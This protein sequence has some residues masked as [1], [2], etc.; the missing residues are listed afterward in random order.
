MNDS[1][2]NIMSQHVRLEAHD[3]T[4]N[5]TIAGQGIMPEQVQRTKLDNQINDR[6]NWYRIEHFKNWEF[7]PNVSWLDKIIEDLKL[8]KHGLS[9]SSSFAR[10]IPIEFAKLYIMLDR[11]DLICAV[12]KIKSGDINDQI[13]YAYL[14]SSPYNYFPQTISSK[15]KKIKKKKLY[16]RYACFGP[17][18]ESHDGEFRYRFNEPDRILDRVNDN[19]KLTLLWDDL[20]RFVKRKINNEDL[21]IY[22]NYFY[23]NTDI[24]HKWNYILETDIESKEYKINFLVI[25]WFIELINIHGN[26]QQNHINE[27]LNRVLFSQKNIDLKFIDQMINKHSQKVVDTFEYMISH[28]TTTRFT[29]TP[30]FGQKIIPLN[31]S[32]VE[33]PLNIRGRP[34]NEI[35]I[36]NIL[37]SLVV[38]VVSPSFPILSDWFYIKTTSKSLFDNKKMYKKK[39]YSKNAQWICRKLEEARRQLYHLGITPEDKNNITL[40]IFEELYHKVEE[41]IDLS[42]IL[43]L[44]NTSLCV[45]SEY[46]GRT[47]ADI[48]HLI[49]NQT[50]YS[51]IF[52]NIFAN[53]SYFRKYMFDIVYSLYCMNSKCGIIHGDL[54]LNNVIIQLRFPEDEN[55]TSDHVYVLYVLNSKS[56]DIPIHSKLYNKTI[57]YES[58]Y[59]T[60]NVHKNK[61]QFLLPHE[62]MYWSIIDFSRSSVHPDFIGLDAFP[63]ENHNN[64]LSQEMKNRY[65]NE[66]RKLIERK[67]INIIESF[68]ENIHNKLK[69]GLIDNFNAIWKLFTAIDTYK[70]SKFLITMLNQ[71]KKQI[72]VDPQCLKL[73]KKIND[74][75][76]YHLNTQLMRTLN[77]KIPSSELEYP[78]FDII[79]ECFHECMVE[80][81]PGTLSAQIKLNDIYIYSNELKYSLDQ[82]DNFPPYA[83]D[84]YGIK[85][86][87]YPNKKYKLKDTNHQK[88]TQARQQL[89]LRQKK[90]MDTIWLISRR[91]NEKNI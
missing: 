20:C 49:S 51:K 80:D 43:T 70:F 69:I 84:W 4:I 77:E 66:Q 76:R 54:H 79:K 22:I 47:I 19:K 68:D 7:S 73:L 48:P 75:S 6:I 16:H 40:P 46:I 88:F 44:S 21:S 63:N 65:V 35:Y 8:D 24:E 29:Q 15:Q 33:N 23:P 39:E 10:T 11:V 45:I 67:Y 14:Y 53:I 27:K 74:I 72:K 12:F 61:F 57:S 60:I 55:I 9:S 90:D 2:K 36:N 78:N 52:S 26:A 17:S 62:F 38:N 32:E 71:V 64:I 82:Y 50:I 13:N 86:M 41:D 89:E 5:R 28:M 18:L 87:K 42:K 91:Q 56:M 83:K 30:I 37:N 58:T 85:D 25:S 34:W 3:D 59:Q 81:I 1:T 31:L